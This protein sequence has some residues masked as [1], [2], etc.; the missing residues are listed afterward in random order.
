MIGTMAFGNL[1]VMAIVFLPLPVKEPNAHSFYVV[2]PL[3]MIY[4]FHCFDLVDSPRARRMAAVLLVM[5]VVYHAGLAAAR[6]LRALAV[7]GPRRGRGGG[8]TQGPGDARPPAAVRQRRERP[9]HRDARVRGRRRAGGPAGHG[10]SWWRGTG[11]SSLFRLNVQNLGTEAAYRDLST[12]RC[13]ATPP[14][15]ARPDRQ[16]RIYEVVQPGET[17]IAR[18]LQR[19]RRGLPGDSGEL[20]LIGAE[21]LV[22]VRR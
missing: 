14:G 6:M 19:R 21:K 10:E 16:G 8:A 13:T 2:A 20:R 1:S 7:Q 11:G 18:R 4:A 9:C 12:R 15:N 22:P 17:R 5:G 3:A